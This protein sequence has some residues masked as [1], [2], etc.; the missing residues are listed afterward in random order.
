MPSA[1]A[2]GASRWGRTEVV[3]PAGVSLPL[4]VEDVVSHW[5]STARLA[6][7]LVSVGYNESGMPPDPHHIE[8]PSALATPVS[9]KQTRGPK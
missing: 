3:T 5:H 4:R 2:L 8:G 9:A 7:A 6:D 1:F